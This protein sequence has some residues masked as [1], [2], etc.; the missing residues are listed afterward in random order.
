MVLTEQTLEELIKQC[1]KKQRSAQAELYQHFAPKMFAVCRLYTNC[2][3]DAQDVFQEAFVH[4]FHKIEQYKNKGSFEGWLRRIMVNTCLEKHRKD[5]KFKLIRKD[6]FNDDDN[7]VT[8]EEN[9]IS[10]ISQSELLELIHQ[11]PERYQMVFVL[12]VLEDYSHNQI[13]EE[14]NITVGTSKSNLSRA[15]A[16]LQEKLKKKNQLHYNQIIGNEIATR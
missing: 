10:K 15:K 12:Y 7:L 1:K 14:L 8:E 3:E 4:A 2:Y 6:D 9:N 16:W 5:S 13:A 11:L